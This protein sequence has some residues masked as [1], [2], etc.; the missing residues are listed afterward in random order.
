MNINIRKYEIDGQLL[1]VIIEDK[2][3]EYDGWM[4][5]EQLKNASAELAVHKSSSTFLPFTEITEVYTYGDSE[6]TLQYCADTGDID[7]TC[8]SNSGMGTFLSKLVSS[9][10]FVLV[11]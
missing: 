2:N 11:T 5:F 8:D 3:N 4:A 1:A 7:I 6:V 10:N 9:Y